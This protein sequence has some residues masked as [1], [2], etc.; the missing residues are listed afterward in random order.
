MQ[1]NGTEVSVGC[2]AF[3]LGVAL[4]SC[5]ID[6]VALLALLFGEDHR[7]NVRRQLRVLVICSF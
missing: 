3:A 6:A 7:T 1:E 2:C 5:W 4:P